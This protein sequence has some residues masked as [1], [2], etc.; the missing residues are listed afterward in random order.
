VMRLKGE[1]DAA[2]DLHTEALSI[3]GQLE[4]RWSIALSHTNMGAVFANRG[5]YEA[6]ADQYRQSLEMFNQMGVKQ[7]IATCLEGLAGVASHTSKPDRAARLF[8]AAEALREEID[9]PIPPAERADYARNLG[10]ARETAVPSRFTSSWIMGRTMT[11]GEAVSL[12]LDQ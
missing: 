5:E 3:F 6:A 1:Y 10:M 2:Y 11:Q 9:V 7:G 8:G 12:A 4:D